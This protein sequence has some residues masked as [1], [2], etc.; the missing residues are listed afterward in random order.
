[1]ALAVARKYR[2]LASW[3]LLA[4]HLMAALA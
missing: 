3:L 4:S 1:M 2:Q